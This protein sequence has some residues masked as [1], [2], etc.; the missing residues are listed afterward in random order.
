V[1]HD[2]TLPVTATVLAAS[3]G[4]L[5]ERTLDSVS[6]AAERVVVDPADRLAGQALPA[7]VRR[8]VGLTGDAGQPRTLLLVEGEIVPPAL[9]DEIRDGL[10][11]GA[12]RM[13]RQLAI[14][15]GTLQPRGAAVRFAPRGEDAISLGRG[16]APALVGAGS[17]TETRH[18]IVVPPFDAMQVMSGMQGE[19]TILAHLLEASGA[20]VR[21]PWIVSTPLV[22]A[23]RVLFGRSPGRLGWGRWVLGVVAG[24]T[25]L[26]SYAKLWELAKR[27]PM[28]PR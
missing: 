8:V 18:A 1:T 14:A 21:L 20:R 5:L 19:S 7:G 17:A 9:R 24:Y 22:V 12:L 27:R 16:F 26:A 11:G 2:E 3:G 25:V 28:V 4:T 10:P 15:G 6:W 23:A 13:P